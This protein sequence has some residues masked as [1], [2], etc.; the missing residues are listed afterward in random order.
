MN[1]IIQ[2]HHQFAKMEKLQIALR[3]LGLLSFLMDTHRQTD[4]DRPIDI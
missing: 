1:E 4:R 2:I 3:V